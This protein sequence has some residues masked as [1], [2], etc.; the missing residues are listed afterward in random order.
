[1]KCFKKYL[2]MVKIFWLTKYPNLDNKKSKAGRNY[3]FS[4]KMNATQIMAGRTWCRGKYSK[5]QIY[6][7]TNIICFD[8]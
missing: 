1:M 5:R 4:F 7:H 8:T 3:L 6:M 2:K